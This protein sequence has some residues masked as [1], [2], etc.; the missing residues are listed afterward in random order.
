MTIDK[1]STSVSHAL[2]HVLGPLLLHIY[3][4]DLSTVSNKVHNVHMFAHM[5]ILLVNMKSYN[6]KLTTI[7]V[8]YR[9]HALKKKTL[10]ISLFQTR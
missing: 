2:G 3:I 7:T 10:R 9:L 5:K 4:Y 1:I 6:L 8:D